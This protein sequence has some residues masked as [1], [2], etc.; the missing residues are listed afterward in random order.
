MQSQ[1]I[2]NITSELSL[3]IYLFIYFLFI[4]AYNVWVI[5][6]PPHSPAHFPLTPTSS[7]TL[8]CFVFTIETQTLSCF[9]N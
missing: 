1:K 3:F 4:C 6:P 5:T 9:L 8:I 2:L 7:P